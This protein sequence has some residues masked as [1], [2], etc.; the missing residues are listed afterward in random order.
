MTNWRAVGL[1]L[2]VEFV[3]GVVGLV[4][5]GIG[6]FVAGFVGGFVAG[7]RADSSIGGG[8]W[9][10]LLA[11]SL[12]GFLLAIPLGIGVSV[13]SIEI[14]VLSQSGGLLAGFGTTLFVIVVAV[15]LGAN[16]ALGGA[17]GS[18]VGGTS[19]NYDGERHSPDRN[20]A[21]HSHRDYPANADHTSDTGSTPV[22]SERD[23]R[24]SPRL[25]D[26]ILDD[27]R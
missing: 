10:G 2:T 23:D 6:Q 14:G 19:R 26:T 12:G 4:V 13:A 17:I 27:R 18:L 15:V 24:S 21:S 9:H 8:L 25:T 20:A 7:Y 16:S 3:L 1:G 22:N 5:P 11:G